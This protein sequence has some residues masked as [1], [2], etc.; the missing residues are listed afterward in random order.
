MFKVLIKPERWVREDELELCGEDIT[1]A[2]GSEVFRGIDEYYKKYKFSE[3]FKEYK[4]GSEALV[5]QNK[6]N[7]EAYAY[8]ASTDWLVVRNLETGIP[9]P[10]DVKEKRALARGSIFH[11]S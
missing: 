4:T 2:V 8:L 11:E 3:I 7:S 6:L 9:I 5:H 10:R 1:Q